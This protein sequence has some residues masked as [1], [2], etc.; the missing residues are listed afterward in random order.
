[1]T[2]T[3]SQISAFRRFNRF[4]TRRIG[5]LSASFLDSDFSLSEVRVLYELAHREAASA[6][7]LVTELGIDAGYLSRMLQSFQGRGLVRRRPSATDGRARVVQLTARGRGR[8]AELDSRQRADVTRLLAPLSAPARREV[9]ASLGAVERTLGASEPSTGGRIELRDLRPGD[10]G[11][12]THRQARLYFE[13]YGWN[14]EYEALIARI[15]ADFVEQ[16]DPAGERCWIA[17]RD[18]EVLG[19]I[20]CVRK[21]KS[22]ARLRL[23]Y[24]EPAA[25]GTGLGTRLV[26]TCIDF[27]REAG[28]TKMTLW[29]NSVLTAARRIYEREGFRL[30]AE[31]KHRNFGKA[32]TSQTWE[33]DLG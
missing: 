3:D 11:W 20:F 6:S 10:I 5:A 7:E 28:Y 13:E 33:R 17:E 21:T 1:M 2:V 8:F 15:M 29:T 16:Y 24:V 30:V 27:A 18:G 12:I 23:L 9:L 22:V 19:S 4:F 32:L 25:R 26:R 31:E 14:A